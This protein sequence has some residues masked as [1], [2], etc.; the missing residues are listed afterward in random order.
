VLGYAVSL[1]ANRLL[2]AMVTEWAPTS[3]RDLTG[4]LALGAGVV[5]VV[6]LDRAPAPQQVP[7]QLLRMALLGGLALWAVPGGRLV[8]TGPAGGALRARPAAL[9]LACRG[10]PGV[11]AVD[12]LVLAIPVMAWWRPRR[13]SSGPSATPV[14]R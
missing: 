5:L 4:N 8:R 7:E 13:R 6:A 1:P 11:P 2:S 3:L 10:G 12:L 9:S 14:R